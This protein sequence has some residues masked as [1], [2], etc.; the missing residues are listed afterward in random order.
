MQLLKITN[1]SGSRQRTLYRPSQFDSSG[2]VFMLNC[3]QDSM[4][5]GDTVPGKC[6]VIYCKF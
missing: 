5:E 2:I 1:R 3:L 4:R 6:K